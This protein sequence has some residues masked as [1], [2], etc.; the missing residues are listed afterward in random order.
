MPGKFRVKKLSVVTG[1][2]AWLQRGSFIGIGEISRCYYVANNNIITPAKLLLCHTVSQPVL[3]MLCLVLVLFV[4]GYMFINIWH[5]NINYPK[6]IM[7]QYSVPRFQ[8]L[9][10]SLALVNSGA[11]HQGECS[12][13]ISQETIY[14]TGACRCCW[15]LWCIFLLNDIIS[16]AVCDKAYPEANEGEVRRIQSRKPIFFIKSW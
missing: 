10:R 6:E 4:T 3:Y 12:K 1:A 8:H 2:V 15:S 16:Y 7:R 5:Q 9:C 13:C 11:V 14:L